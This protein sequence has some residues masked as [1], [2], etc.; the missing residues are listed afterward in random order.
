MPVII[1]EVVRILDTPLYASAAPFDICVVV[2]T[3]VVYVTDIIVG[4]TFGI[5][6]INI[7]AVLLTTGDYICV[8]DGVCACGDVARPVNSQQINRDSRVLLEN[9]EAFG[10]RQLVFSVIPQEILILTLF[11][12][13]HLPADSLRDESSLQF[14]T[15]HGA[16][17]HY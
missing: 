14:G 16:A 8:S 5:L 9:P 11:R 6:E 4:N 1:A 17:D 7:A 13:S 12:Y 15:V 2:S 3:L 10:R